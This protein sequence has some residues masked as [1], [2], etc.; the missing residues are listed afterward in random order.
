MKKLIP[1]LLALV[2]LLSAC[3]GKAE[4][5]ET[6][7]PK[8]TPAAEPEPTESVEP[9][10][11]IDGTLLTAL[12]D[13]I[14]V[15][16]DSDG[17]QDEVSLSRGEDGLAL[18]VNG[19]DFSDV[20]YSVCD[21]EYADSDYFAVVNLDR[22]DRALEV[23]VEDFGPSD[24]PQTYFFRYADETVT[25]VGSVP[26]LAWDDWTKKDAVTYLG[27]GEVL[28]NA[29]LDGLMTWF[30]DVV[31]RIGHDGKLA[32]ARG[33]M[34]AA[35][36]LVNVTIT[37]PVLVYESTDAEPEK[38]Y[39]GETLQLS[40]TDQSQWVQAYRSGGAPVLLR[41]NPDNLY[42]VETPSGFEDGPQV[43]NGLIF[44]G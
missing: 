22:Y 27:G 44:A 29:R 37:N 7:T 42:Q 13:A 40:G 35:D 18:T 43:M 26:S 9:G 16:L 6:Y 20:L 38:L 21:F 25:C 32:M 11:Q 36:Q 24:D 8:Y 30:G 12:G 39:P 14:S 15:D 17:K 41:L 31:Y 4:P 3:A 1:L 5:E 34:C 10:V 33:E 19:K 2:L 23:A 28:V